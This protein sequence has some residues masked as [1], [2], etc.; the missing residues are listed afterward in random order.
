MVMASD[1][2]WRVG[3]KGGIK[4]TKDRYWAYGESKYVTKDE[5]KMKE[6]M[7]VK[8]KAQDYKKGV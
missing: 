7:W 1:K 4:I 3:P 2:V 6:F 5:T 8:L